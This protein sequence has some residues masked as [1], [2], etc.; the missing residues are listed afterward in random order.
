VAGRAGVDR[1]QVD[2]LIAAGLIS[3]QGG[4]F[5]AGDVRRVLLLRGLVDGGLPLEAISQ[6]VRQRLLSMDFADSDVYRRF[7]SLSD[8]TFADVSE[9]TGIPLEWL[10]VMREAT[11]WGRFDPSARLREDELGILPWLETQLRL[12]FRRPAVERM[13]RALGDTLRRLAEAEAE[14]FRTEIAEPYIAQG[15]VDEITLVDPQNHFSEQGEQAILAVLRA[16]QA[17]T[18][19]GNMVT[20]IERTLARAGLHVPVTRHPTICFLDITGY[21]RLTQ[22]RGDQAAADLAEAL[23][24]LVKHTSN[25]HGGRPVKWLGDGVMFWFRDPGPAVHAALEMVDGVRA[26]GLPPA[27]VGLHTGPVVVQEGDYYGQTVNMAARMA[28]YARPGEVLVSRSVVD[29][30]ADAGL[31]FSAIGQVELKGVVGTTELFVAR[32]TG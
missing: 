5:T 23:A 6:A 4:G 20:G 3:E 11:G 2:E 9:R 31:E 13:L 7:A 28:D 30:A 27:H 8:Q 24:K 22:E 17:Q 32:R 10:A 29:T 1:A 12:G 25:D 19:V 14:W 16:Q 18:W 26:E 15:R 21:T